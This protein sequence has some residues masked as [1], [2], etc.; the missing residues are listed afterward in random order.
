M[1]TEIIEDI[2]LFCADDHDGAVVGYER[3]VFYRERAAAM[4][5]SAPYSSAQA[6]VEVT[7]AS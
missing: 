2:A 1:C 4:Y 3:S 6:I 7:G 5:S